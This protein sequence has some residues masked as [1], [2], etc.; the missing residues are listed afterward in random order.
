MRSAWNNAKRLQF[1]VWFAHKDLNTGR[2]RPGDWLNLQ[3]DINEFLTL[4]GSHKPQQLAKRKRAGTPQDMSDIPHGGIIARPPEGSVFPHLSEDEVKVLQRDTLIIL[5]TIVNAPSPILTRHMDTSWSPASIEFLFDIPT[6]V[7]LIRQE[8]PPEPQGSPWRNLLGIRGTARDMF[9]LVLC[10][11]LMLESTDRILPCPECKKLFYR[12]RRQE[13]CS[14]ACVNR[15][16]VR[17]WRATEEGK[18]QEAKRARAKYERKVQQDTG[19][20]VK[21]GTRRTRQ[22]TTQEEA[23]HAQTPR[24]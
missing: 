23:S 3:D 5:Y 11:V 21:V 4:Q 16:N 12:I 10:L 17:K 8:P 20:K 7:T 22:E 9:R 6:R 13:Y 14:R 24:Q 15:A 2:M 1:A 19:A 18:Q